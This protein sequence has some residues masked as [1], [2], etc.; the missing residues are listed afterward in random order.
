MDEYRRTEWFR[1]EFKPPLQGKLK[2]AKVMG[3]EVASSEGLIEIIDISPSGMKLSTHLEI[4]IDDAIIVAVR[5]TI[6]QLELCYEANLVWHKGSY[7]GLRLH[8]SEQQEESLV[9][10]IKYYAKKNK[11]EMKDSRR[12]QKQENRQVYGE[13]YQVYQLHGGHRKWMNRFWDEDQAIKFAKKFQNTIVVHAKS[14]A[15]VY[16]KDVQ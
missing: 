1:F 10:E 15:V 13:T 7:Y 8:T 9:Q 11:V 16:G 2:I 5:F 12:F 4:P 3:R 6:N 14:Q